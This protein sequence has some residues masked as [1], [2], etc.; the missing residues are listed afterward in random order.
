MASKYKQ[1]KSLHCDLPF[2]ILY[3]M[4]PHAVTLQTFSKSCFLEAEIDWRACIYYMFIIFY[5]LIP[6]YNSKNIFP[7]IK[8]DVDG[9]LTASTFI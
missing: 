9:Q 2:A 6:I 1:T 5:L 3:V 8:M 4:F 7:T